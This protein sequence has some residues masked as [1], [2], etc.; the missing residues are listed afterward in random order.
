MN[1]DFPEESEEAEYEHYI[2]QLA[3]FKSRYPTFNFS[4]L[5]EIPF[6]ASPPMRTCDNTQYTSETHGDVEDSFGMLFSVPIYGSD[7]GFRGIISVI[8]RSNIF[9]AVLIDRPF[10]I[11]TELAA[12]AG[13]DN[14]NNT[15]SPSA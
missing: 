12:L 6:I 7:D 13:W 4:S 1:H 11:V 8:V 10:V 2:K 3:F 15:D 14:A 9:E 5:D